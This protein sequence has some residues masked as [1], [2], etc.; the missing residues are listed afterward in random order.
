MALRWDRWRG[1]AKEQLQEN[2]R[3]QDTVIP[4]FMEQITLGSEKTIDNSKTSVFSRR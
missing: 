4:V 1:Y 2:W 3:L